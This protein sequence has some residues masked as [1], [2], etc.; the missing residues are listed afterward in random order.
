ML[1]TFL[2]YTVGFIMEWRWW[3]ENALKFP[4]PWPYYTFFPK[5]QSMRLCVYTRREILV[6][7]LWKKEKLKSSM[8]LSRMN[9]PALIARLDGSRRRRMSFWDFLLNFITTIKIWRMCTCMN[10]VH[11]WLVD[12]SLRGTFNSKYWI[13]IHSI[14]YYNRIPSVSK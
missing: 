8:N 5:N 12:T 10:D 9:L 3:K 7:T 2:F 14:F 13:Y 1:Q 11:L 6:S 4:F